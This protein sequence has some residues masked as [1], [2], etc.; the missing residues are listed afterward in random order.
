MILDR[1]GDFVKDIVIYGS[2]EEA[3]NDLDP[4]SD[5]YIVSIMNLPKRKL[6]KLIK[7]IKDDTK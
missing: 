5:G 3:Y 1:N 4:L 2:Y 7:Y 6:E